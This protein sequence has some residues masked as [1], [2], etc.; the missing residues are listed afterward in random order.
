MRVATY[1]LSVDA[2]Q[3]HRCANLPHNRVPACLTRVKAGCVHLHWEAGNTVLI[4]PLTINSK[5][6]APHDLLRYELPSSVITNAL[7]GFTEKR[8]ERF[9]SGTSARWCVATDCKR[10]NQHLQYVWTK[11]H[12]YITQQHKSSQ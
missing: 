10:G 11:W 6:R 4:W 8:V 5:T 9:V 12:T 1:K 3:K 2:T 7:V